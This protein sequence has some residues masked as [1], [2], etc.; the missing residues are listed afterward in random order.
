MCIRDRIQAVH[1][2]TGL[3]AARF[4]LADRGLVREGYHADLVL[5]N[6]DTVIDRATFAAPVQTAAGI[7]AVW[8]N[9]V[10]SYHQGQPTGDRAGRW[11]PRNG[12]LHASFAAASSRSPAS[13]Q[14]Q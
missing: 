11:L 3:S 4:G 10:L 8:V 5:F 12:D 6:P 1:K 9:G 2:M 7:E 13:I 14:S